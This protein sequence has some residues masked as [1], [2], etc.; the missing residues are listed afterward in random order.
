MGTQS[1]VQSVSAADLFDFLSSNFHIV[2]ETCQNSRNRNITSDAIQSE[3]S[4]LAGFLNLIHMHKVQLIG[5]EEISWLDALDARSRWEALIQLQNLDVM[6]LIVCDAQTLPGDLVES[7]NETGIPVWSSRESGIELLAH[8]QHYL[9]LQL[10]QVI[11]YHGVFMEVFSVGVIITGESGTGKSELALELISRGHRLV[12][13][14]APEFSKI[15]PDTLAGHC[16][17]I[18]KDCIEVRGLGILNVRAMFGDSAVITTKYLKLI[19][20]LELMKEDMFLKD[21]EQARLTGS[22]SSVNL[23]GIDIPMTTL[24]VA[25][26]RNLAVL[27]EAAVRNHALKMQGYHAA[28]KFIERQRQIMQDDSDT[29]RESESDTQNDD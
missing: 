4:D 7:T 18:L 8:I 15:A 9:T 2:W 3:H 22:E 10:A 17:D 25:P 13:D 20:H 14:D 11:T 24:P 26:G 28:D 23:L 27:L 16:P 29:P 12:A 6:A 19:V 21:A 5:P 1:V